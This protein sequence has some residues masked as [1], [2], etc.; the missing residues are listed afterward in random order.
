MKYKLIIFA[1]LI[2]S[3]NTSI[4]SMEPEEKK[5]HFDLTPEE[6]AE[7]QLSQQEEAEASLHITA[8]RELLDQ[9]ERKERAAAR[10]VRQME[11]EHRQFVREV[12]RLGDESSKEMLQMGL[13]PEK[14]EDVVKYNEIY[15]QRSAKK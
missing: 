15:A 14:L 6:L 8:G 11:Q 7:L 12:S 13:N 1:I 2:L 9:I 5:I 10:A 4:F 3:I